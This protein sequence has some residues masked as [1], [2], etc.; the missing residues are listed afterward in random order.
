[1]KHKIRLLPAWLFWI[2]LG[3]II[4]TYLI[5]PLLVV[6]RGVLRLKPISKAEVNL[7][8][9]TSLGSDA[10]PSIS[11][12]I[13]AYNEAAGIG[14]KLENALSLNY[15]PDRLQVI[16][17]SDGSDD[18]TNS[19]VAGF[20]SPQIRLLAL[21]RQGKNATINQ[22]VAAAEGEILVFTDADSILSADSLLYLVA[23]FT[24]REV[25]GV[26]GSYHY[27]DNGKGGEGRT[28]LLEF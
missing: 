13:A 4:Y 1:M 28:R 22:A 24:D 16:V 25:G 9:Y 11:L 18:A 10:L 6:L 20:E 15:P 5:F 17:A 19:I 14:K 23:P 2:S 7:D 21:P 12:I 26:G 3:L 8:S 27:E